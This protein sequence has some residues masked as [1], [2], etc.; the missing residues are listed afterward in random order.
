MNGI[1]CMNGSFIHVGDA[2][3]SV[4]DEGF[5]YGYGLF[6][7]ILVRDAVPLLLEPHLIRMEEGARIIGI[8][9]PFSLQEIG[10][11]VRETIRRNGLM[12]GSLRLTLSA[13]A[14]PRG[15]PNLVIFTRPPKYGEKHK[16]E[17][18]KACLA[19]SRRNEHSILNRVKGL[20]YLEN[21]LARREAISKGFEEAI[22]LNTSGYLS[23]G[24]AT[25]IFLVRDGVVVT[26]SEDQGILPGIMRGFVI[27]ICREQGVQV[28]ERRVELKELLDSEESFLTN[29]L[30]EVMPLVQLEGHRIGSGKPGPLTRW[31]D[32]AIRSKV[33]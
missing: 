33:E 27:K 22:F 10:D 14:T 16:A 26:P 2:K 21:I 9:I 25:N 5:L 28:I 19:R 32:R 13:G 18:I 20:S 17:G 8:K 24:S 7:T 23:E 4:M 31:L 1:V 11:L 6:E 15:N 3:I 30:M 12:F 29:S